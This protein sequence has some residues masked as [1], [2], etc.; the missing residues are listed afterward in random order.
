MQVFIFRGGSS[1]IKFFLFRSCLFLFVLH[2]LSE[3]S[4]DDGKC[5]IE[6]EESTDEN[7]GVE[8]D[9]DPHSN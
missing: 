6:K 8:V 3:F 7:N 9:N 2:F 4:L 1:I 5:Q